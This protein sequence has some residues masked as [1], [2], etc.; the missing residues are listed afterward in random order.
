MDHCLVILKCEHLNWGSK[1][2]RF[3]NCWL[4]HHD[5][6]PFIFNCWKELH[7]E[8]W[9]I[10]AFWEKL[11]LLKFRLKQWNKDEF[12]HLDTN[13]NRIVDELNSLDEAAILGEVNSKVA[14]Q[15]RLLTTEMWQQLRLKE[16][17]L[18]QKSI[19]K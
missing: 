10:F 16:S 13:L 9:H 2:F 3:H 5:F 6:L 8:G 7:V 11:K 17:L 4:G 12:C 18:Y 1:P 19:I 15:R 14:E